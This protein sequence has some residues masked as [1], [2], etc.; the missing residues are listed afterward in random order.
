[1]KLSR[2]AAFGS[3]NW[4]QLR[5]VQIPCSTDERPPSMPNQSRDGGNGEVRALG[6]SL[7]DVRGF[8]IYTQFAYD[9][10]QFAYK[11]LGGLQIQ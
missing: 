5:R 7:G 9:Y 11:Q 6:K 1:M 8:S 10:T 4:K 2:A 3:Q